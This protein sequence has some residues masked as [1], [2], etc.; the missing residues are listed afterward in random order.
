MT[1]RVGDSSCEVNDIKSQILKGKPRRNI[2]DKKQEVMGTRSPSS[3]SRDEPK[4]PL[5]R[6]PPNRDPLLLSRQRGDPE[7]NMV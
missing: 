3:R 1:T 2:E 6:L 7:E 4:V 5:T